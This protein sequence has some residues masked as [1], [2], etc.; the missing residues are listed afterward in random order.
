MTSKSEVVK[1][2]VLIMTTTLVAPISWGLNVPDPDP[3]AVHVVSEH[4]VSTSGRRQDRV[5]VALTRVRG[6]QRGCC[7]ES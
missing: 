1:V 7:V 2:E 6:L 4:E 5:R 3:A